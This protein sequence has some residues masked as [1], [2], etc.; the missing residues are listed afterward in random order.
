MN[1]IPLDQCENGYLYKIQ[2]RNLSFGVYRQEVKG[3]VGIRE[4]FGSKYLF[5]EYH[6]DTGPPLGTVHPITKLEKCPVEQLNEGFPEGGL[7]K[8][9]KPLFDWLQEK[10]REYSS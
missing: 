6:W 7:Y 10:E 5:T 8:T 3:F 2:S 1:Y 9:N 4:K